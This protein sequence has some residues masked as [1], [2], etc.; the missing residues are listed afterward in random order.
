MFLTR[1][2]NYTYELQNRSLDV[3]YGLERSASLLSLLS[4]SVL[5]FLL[6]FFLP[7]FLSCSVFSALGSEKLPLFPPKA[8][9]EMTLMFVFV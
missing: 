8:T 5:S 2:K 6:T 9:A 4:F 3:L 7:F 1:A